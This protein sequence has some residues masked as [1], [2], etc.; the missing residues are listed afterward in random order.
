MK[1]VLTMVAFAV[2]MAS[3]VAFA[4]S[5]RNGNRGNNCQITQTGEI[6]PADTFFSKVHQ[7]S[8]REGCAAGKLFKQSRSG[9]VYVNGRKVGD[10]LSNSEMEAV[11][12]QHAHGRCPVYSCDEY[13]PRGTTSDDFNRNG[14]P[15][16]PVS[17]GGSG[18]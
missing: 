17:G 6:I 12:A 3:T 15:R 7:L 10:G 8:Q 11:I 5:D 2:A 4:Q 1:H 9:R 18:W 14:T 16:P 13:G